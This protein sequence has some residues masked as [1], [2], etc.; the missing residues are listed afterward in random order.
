LIQLF[1]NITTPASDIAGPITLGLMAV[2]ERFDTALIL[3]GGLLGA[4]FGQLIWTLLGH[5]QKMVSPLNVQTVLKRGAI[6][7][8]VFLPQITYLCQGKALLFAPFISFFGLAFGIVLLSLLEKKDKRKIFFAHPTESD[9]TPVDFF[10]HGSVITLGTGVGWFIQSLPGMAVT[11]G[12]GLWFALSVGIGFWI[13]SLLFA[14]LVGLFFS[15][16]TFDQIYMA[17]GLSLLPLA[18]LPLQTLG[19][20][21]YLKAGNVVTR[22]LAAWLPVVLPVLV[23]TGFVAIL[24]VSLLGLRRQ[25]VETSPAWEELFR[26]LMLILGVPL[27]LYAVAYNP[28]GAAFHQQALTGSLDLFNEGESLGVAQAMLSGKLPFK[29]IFLRHG[30]LSDAVSGLAA[31]QWFGVSVASL[32]MLMVLLAPLGLVAIYLLAIFCLPWIWALLLSIVLLTGHLGTIPMTRFFFPIIGFIFTLY[33]IQRGRWIILV[34]SG[35]VTVLSL[36][37][38]HTA[39][40]IALVGN[41]F[42]M[43]AY[44]LFGQSSLKNRVIQFGIYL[45]ATVL[46][47]LPWW[48]YLGMSGSL[49]AY[50]SNFSWVI[51]QYTAVYGLPISSWMENPPIMQMLLFALPPGVV[52]VGALMIIQAVKTIRQTGIFPWNV[53]VLVVFTGMLWMRFLSRSDFSYLADVLPMAAM[54]MAFFI[55]RLTAKQQLLRGIVFAALLP[56]A[57]FPQS[58]YTTLP[59]LAGAFG[60]KN[61]IAIDGLKSG[62]S[63]RLENLFLPGQEAAALDQVIEYLEGQVGTTESFYDFSN[64]P[65]LYFLVPRKPVVKTLSTS[66]AATFEQQLDVIR[67]L[68]NADLKSVLFQGSH[69]TPMAL[70]NIPSVVR[71]YAISE[72]LLQT[73]SPTAVIANWVMLSPP[74]EGLDP[75]VKAIAALKKPVELHALPLQWGALGKYDP[76]QGG[77]V[78]RYLATAGIKA[79]DAKDV[80]VT[81]RGET[82]RVAGVNQTVRLELVRAQGQSKPANVLVMA[83]TVDT[84]LDKKQAVLSWGGDPQQTIAF[85]LQGDQKTHRYAFRL[86]ALPAWVYADSQSKLTLA[87]PGGGWTWESAVLLQVKDISELAVKTASQGVGSK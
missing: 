60:E 72:Y 19:W 10:T 11:V 55:Y 18:L 50:F 38:S 31:I 33:F 49:G 5:V 82:I 16:K 29:E 67:H 61:K 69:R 23:G 2:H 44:T 58:G 9:Y 8:A 73:F 46:C 77:T 63:E 83:M 59:E 25:T 70:D 36:I 56:A 34:F 68:S 40:I 14:A 79:V 75:D 87:M 3:L 65:L 54:L 47:L 76:N 78:G 20:I 80:T 86:G 64:Q 81:A 42:L 41:L 6:P 4:V 15:K 74:I 43:T 7:F 71:Q 66:T 52:V 12:G 21:D 39:G 22:Q 24:I 57:F 28:L 45:G 32:R 51:T 62:K 84:Q 53:L 27:L 17:L 85:T 48:L 13:V 37:A 26:A 35:L 30:F 1:G